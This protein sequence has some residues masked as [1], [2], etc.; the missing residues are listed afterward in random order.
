MASMGIYLFNKDVLVECLENDLID[1]GSDI[2]PVAAAE[3]KVQAHFFK[4]YWKDIGTIQAFY[5]AHMDLVSPNPPFHFNDPEWPFYT[6]PQYLPGARLDD[7]RFKRSILCEGTRVIESVV[8]RS[9]IGLRTSVRGATV[10][11]SL[12]MGVDPNPPDAPSGT[13]PL[14]VGEG[15]VIEGA[16]VDKNARIGRNV[17][18]TN[19]DRIQEADGDG[20]VIRE[21]IVVVTKNAI[22]P[23]DTKI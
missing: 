18:I 21:G 20:W 22:I 13:P 23:D 8:E 11:R 17:S 3:R 9:V 4:G 16:I 12:V 1:F 6:W 19:P 15:A 14:G 2:I 7:S 5:D 10:R